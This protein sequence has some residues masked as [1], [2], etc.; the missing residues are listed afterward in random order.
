M[1]LLSDCNCIWCFG[2]Y[3]R[4]C[5]RIHGECAYHGR[6]PVALYVFRHS[7]KFAFRTAYLC[8][9][10]DSTLSPEQIW[11]ILMPSVVSCIFH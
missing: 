7:P 3:G 9:K 4:C 2:C 6:N 11:E 5:M 8:E 1:I 10:C